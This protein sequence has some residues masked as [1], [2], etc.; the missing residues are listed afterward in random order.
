MEHLI[1][2]VAHILVEKRESLIC[3]V[4]E[5]VALVGVANRILVRP[6]LKLLLLGD[7]A[8]EIAQKLLGL[9]EAVSVVP[10]DGHELVI[11]DDSPLQVCL[12]QQ[13]FHLVV[14]L[15]E[16]SETLA[17]VFEVFL[18]ELIVGSQHPLLSVQEPFVVW[19]NDI[20]DAFNVLPESVGVDEESAEWGQVLK[21][22]VHTLAHDQDHL[23]PVVQLEQ[24][25]VFEGPWLYS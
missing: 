24:V 9:D 6:H 23:E 7:E 19:V 5:D 11:D 14:F 20:K 8:V 15:L 3:G 13:W 10:I 25:C 4:L 18:L 2:I 1:V 16:V 21:H 17:I 12:A 22:L